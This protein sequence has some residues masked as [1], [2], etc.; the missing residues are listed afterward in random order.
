MKQTIQFELTQIIEP[1][2]IVKYNSHIQNYGWEDRY[3]KRDG[4]ITGTTGKAKRLEAIKISLGNSEQIPQGA[5]IEYQVH[6]QDIGWQGW[7]QN[8][9]IAG[10][11][12]REKRIEAIRIKTIRN[13]R[14]FS[15][16]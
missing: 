16:I 10:T 12:G 8:G 2:S 6:I 13:G 7:K 15:R 1:E 14:L 9:E 3:S 5:K 11:E 4:D